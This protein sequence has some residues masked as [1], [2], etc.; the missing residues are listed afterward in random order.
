MDSERTKMD[1]KMVGKT[2]VSQFVLALDLQSESVT[3][4][5]SVRKMITR[6]R[7]RDKLVRMDL[8]IP[9]HKDS[10]SRGFSQNAPKIRM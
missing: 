1:T 4:I 7:K 8:I 10:A 3:C 5:W 9:I 2:D 6:W